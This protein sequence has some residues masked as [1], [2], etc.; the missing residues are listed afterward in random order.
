M[1]GPSAVPA[2]V[3][4][5]P[6]PVNAVDASS[7]F[8]GSEFHG[9]SPGGRWLLVSRG[10]EGSHILHDLTSSGQKSYTLPKT[11]PGSDD[12][13][14]GPGDRWLLRK[15]GYSR[16]DAEPL[17]AYDLADPLR[18]AELLPSP[19][20]RVG[21][22]GSWATGGGSS[23]TG[24]AGPVL[25]EIGKAVPTARPALD[26]S[27]GVCDD[28][29]WMA[30]LTDGLRGVRLHNLTF[31]MRAPLDLGEVPGSGPPMVRAV[32]DPTSRKILLWDTGSYGAQTPIFCH[33]LEHREA[34][35]RAIKCEGFKVGSGGWSN[36]V[37]SRRTAAGSR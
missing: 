24:T 37:S 34:A 27:P 4:A 26:N 25:W 6:K 32:F 17:L 31:R 30:V 12:W 1:D 5:V 3:V 16:S 29:R 20:P 11:T 33:D 9:I 18:P 15:P 19:V 2:V 35:P 23:A 36:G 7:S 14:F 10:Q 21:R 8:Y 28:G 13:Q 22:S